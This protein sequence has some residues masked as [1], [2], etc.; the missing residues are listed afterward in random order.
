MRLGTLALAVTLSVTGPS[1]APADWVETFDSGGF[2]QTWSFGSVPDG[3]AFTSTSDG[4]ELLIESTDPAGAGAVA[5][6]GLVT[7]EQ[8][9]SP[10][11]T[12]RSV[13]N[14]GGIALNDDIGVLAHL[15]PNAF[16]GY[17]FTID[18]GGS[19]G[20]FDLSRITAGDAE[21]LA[22]SNLANFDRLQ[23]YVV[24]L[25][26]AGGQLTARVLDTDDNVLGELN[27][28]DDN[29][30]AGGL[31]GVV[32]QRDVGSNQLRGTFGLTSAT[33]VP[34]PSSVAGLGL[35]AVAAVYLR[36]RR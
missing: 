4:G 6:F 28:V 25:T 34:E 8:F 33:A 36:R 20:S 2:D 14:P 10:G 35:V 22:T 26:V 23:T 30:W 1:V 12:V 21:G 31:A 32:A 16:N 5:A 13:L 24:E 27:T 3:S 15:D 29:P 11:V 17:A 19:T 7:T 9:S 18:Y